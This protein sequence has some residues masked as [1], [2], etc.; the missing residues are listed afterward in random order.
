M[1]HVT[2][3]EPWYASRVTWG[4]IIAA[5]APILGLVLGRTVSVADQAS[6]VEIGTAAGTL[7]GAG[8]ALYGRWVAKTPIG[9]K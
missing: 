8:L 9:S 2:N 7:A 3:A 5:L 1:R 6:I 4:A